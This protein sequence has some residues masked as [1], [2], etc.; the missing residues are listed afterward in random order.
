M[1]K[2]T[3]EIWESEAGWG[4]KPWYNKYF[5]SIKEAEEF[6]KEY[7]SQNTEDKVPGWYSFAKMGSPVDQIN[8]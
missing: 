7:N 8:K 2:Q 3:V 5:D 4:S 6:I 1:I